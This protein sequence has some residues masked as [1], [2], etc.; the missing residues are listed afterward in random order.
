[1]G[2]VRGVADAGGGGSD[3]IG[4]VLH[5]SGPGGAAPWGQ[6]LGALD[7]DELNIERVHMGFLRQVTGMKARSLGD[8]TWTKEGPDRVMQAEVTKPLWE[9][10]NK[11]KATVA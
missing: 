8:K 7:S 1:M 2:A 6:D 9:Y 4:K 11:R 5:G 10:I 3:L